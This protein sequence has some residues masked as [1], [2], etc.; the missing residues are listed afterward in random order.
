MSS[1]Y[2][3]PYKKSYKR[4]RTMGKPNARSKVYK[5][6]I[7]NQEC[8]TFYPGI[9]WQF[10]LPP[11]Y[12]TSMVSR[13]T[14]YV[15]GGATSGG[16]FTVAFNGLQNPFQTSANIP[17]FALPL[18][19]DPIGYGTLVDSTR[20]RQYRVFASIIEVETLVGNAA[21]QVSLCILPGETGFGAGSY[22]NQLGRPLAKSRSFS[23]QSDDKK[24]K[25]S[26]KIEEVAGITT[27]AIK[28]DLSGVIQGTFSAVPADSYEWYVYYSNQ[29]ANTFTGNCIWTVK[30]TQFV[31]LFDLKTQEID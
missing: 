1:T 3:K 19:T 31:E 20:Y 6:A 23:S 15:A 12:R 25:N 8:V 5:K 22:V 11:R 10:P 4:K 14:G 28:N 17:N 24:L 30:L 16:F 2:K 29:T 9:G 18:S 21:D 7:K 13:N 26:C 27:E